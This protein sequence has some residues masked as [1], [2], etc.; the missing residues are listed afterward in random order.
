MVCCEY[1]ICCYSEEYA[2]TGGEW[3]SISVLGA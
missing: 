2:R 3:D 1:I